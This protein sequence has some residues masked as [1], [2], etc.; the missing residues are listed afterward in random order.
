MNPANAAVLIM[1]GIRLGVAGALHPSLAEEY[2]LK[3][4]VFLAEI[5]FEQLASGAFTPVHY[6][7][8]ARYPAVQRD[9]SVIV[10]RD[11]P[12]RDLQLGVLDL[13][14]P[15]LLSVALV[16]VYEGEKIPA[17]KLSLTLRFVFQDREKTLTVDRVQGFSDNVLNF[18]RTN[19]GAELRRLV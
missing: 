15:E 13:Q 6:Q 12:Y 19:Y 11:I 17:G 4:P 7:P 9:L 2:K 1:N 18:L 10:A 14:I 5:D 16:D 3:Q 8:L